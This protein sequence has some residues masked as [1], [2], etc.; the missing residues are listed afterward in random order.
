MFS[1]SSNKKNEKGQGLVEYAIILA[2]VAIVVI[3]V[4]RIL[5]PKVGC[6][7]SGINDSLPGGSGSSSTCGAVAAAP[8][9]VTLNYTCP[10]SGMVDVKNMSG[11]P[12]GASFSCSSGAS[13]TYTVTGQTSGTQM[14]LRNMYPPYNVLGN[15]TVP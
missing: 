7:F 12:N 10:S 15:V 4:M 5:G 6:T 1:L 14:Q 13:L 8:A 9:P 2:L 3:G 11:G